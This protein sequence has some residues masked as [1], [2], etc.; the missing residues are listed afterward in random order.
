MT[1]DPYRIH[2]GVILEEVV[3]Y[4]LSR[5]GYLPIID[6]IG[7]ESLIFDKG[8]L[9]VKGRGSEHQID[10]IADSCYSPPFCHQQRLLIEAKFL[11]QKVGL[12]V[13]R[14]ATGVIKDVGEFWVPVNRAKNSKR[15]HYM[16]GVFSKS[17]FSKPAQQYAFAHDIYLLPLGRNTFFKPIIDTIDRFGT[18]EQH[19]EDQREVPKPKLVRRY[20]RHE[21]LGSFGSSVDENIDSSLLRQLGRIIEAV[22]TQGSGYM[23]TFGGS[24]PVFLMAEKNI[25]EMNLSDVTDVKIYFDVSGWYINSLDENK[26]FSFDLPEELFNLYA[27]SGNLSKQKAME[28][29]TRDMAEFDILLYSDNQVKLKKFE[30]SGEWVQSVKRNLKLEG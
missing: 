25:N 17:E 24:F 5:N 10:A 13:I 8:A 11:R 19:E 12:D 1:V 30:L 6:A 28:L 9:R 4:I 18:L 29:K 7:D 3:L 22:K 26:L 15:Y 16:Y 2:R 14:N 20:L 27:E 23:T 21:L